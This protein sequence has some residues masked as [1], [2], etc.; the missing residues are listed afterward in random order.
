MTIHW[1]IDREIVETG[2]TDEDGEPITEIQGQG[3]LHVWFHDSDPAVDAPDQ[4]VSSDEHDFSW[5]RQGDDLIP[6]LEVQQV[7]ADQEIEDELQGDQP[8]NKRMFEIYRD[9]ATEQIFR[10]GEDS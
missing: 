1:A 6:P 10:V 9:L 8:F 4:V 7:A 2:E 5:T 3:D